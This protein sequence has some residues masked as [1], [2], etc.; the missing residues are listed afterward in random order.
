MHIKS[1]KGQAL[2]VILG[3]LVI[4]LVFIPSLV[5]MVQNESKWTVK[6]KKTTSAFHAAEAGLDRGI[7]KLSESA[8]NWDTIM[9]GGTISGYTG[10]TV[11]NLYLDSLNTVIGGQ[12]KVNITAGPTTDAITIRSIG[13]DASDSEVRGIEAIYSRTSMNAS[14]TVN[15]GIKWKPNLVIHWGPVVTYTSVTMSP[16]QYY[17]RKFSKGAIAGRDTSPTAP[18]SDGKEYW[19][20]ED[21]G[22]APQVDLAYYKNLALQSRIPSSAGGGTIRKATGGSAAVASPPGSGFFRAAD[23]NGGVRFFNSYT[24]NNSTSVIYC[25]GTVDFTNTCFIRAQAVIGEG[26]VDFNAKN[27]LYPAKVPSNAGDEYVKAKEVNPGYTYPGEGSATYTVPDCGMHGFL[28]CGGDMNNAG[29]N[30]AMV[31]VADVIGDVN[32]NVFTIYYDV[33]I[34]TSLRLSNATS[35]QVSW[36]EFSASWD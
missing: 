2:I 17:P 10:T 23:N 27:T 11:Y 19:A 26:N 16:N 13:R 32:I 21:L 3:I 20:F 30:A 25:D 1:E 28:Y 6:S 33:A 35:R 14:L 36:K 8:S 9:G 29:G 15:G 34:S 5:F 12:Y 18:N 24:F 31:G 22:T 4:F 7:W